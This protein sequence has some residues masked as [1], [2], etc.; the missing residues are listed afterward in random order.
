MIQ[1]G[2]LF[3]GILLLVLSAVSLSN[4]QNITSLAIY[5]GFDLDLGF[6][7]VIFFLGGIFSLILSTKKRV[8][9][10]AAI[11][12]LMTYGWAILA[13][14]IAVGFLGYFGIFNQNSFNNPVGILNNPFYL[15]AWSLTDSKI[16]LEIRN[17]GYE[18]NSIEGVT[19]SFDG[20]QCTNSSSISIPSGSTKV[21]SIPCD[22]QVNS[23]FKGDISVT[24]KK[25]SSNLQQSTQGSIRSKVSQSNQETP[26]PPVNY[27]LIVNLNG[28]GSVSC[29][30]A[31]CLSKY[32]ENTA[33]TL[34][35]QPASQYDFTGWSGSGCSGVGS[36]S[37][38]MTSNKTVNATF[39]A[40]DL[41]VEPL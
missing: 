2:Y 24:Y 25:S 21:V 27:T 15:N 6:G 22:L 28:Q 12:F 31:S 20:G 8:K 36:C 16:D 9:G 4:S 32:E 18:D 37:I 1:K 26:L 29:N 30:G 14:T 38:T 39:M 17:S 35:A 7:G 3:L 34:T 19:I 40:Q 33:L 11:E 23:N 10:Q 5:D 13:A 41:G